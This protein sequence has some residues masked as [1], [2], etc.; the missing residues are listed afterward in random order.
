MS[1]KNG[2]S[3]VGRNLRQIVW[4]VCGVS[5]WVVHVVGGL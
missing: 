3:Y 2:C 1:K 4:S 5:A